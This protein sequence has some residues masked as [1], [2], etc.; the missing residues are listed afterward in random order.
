MSGWIVQV[1]QSSANLP[2]RGYDR[3][4]NPRRPLVNTD[5][6]RA[7]VSRVAALFRGLAL[8]G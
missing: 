4:K 5:S 3:G 7:P 8:C 6:G 2:D 1:V